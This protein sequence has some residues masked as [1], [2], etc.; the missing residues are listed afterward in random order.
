MLIILTK[1]CKD[2]DLWNYY[3][4]PIF[5]I[6]NIFMGHI[7]LCSCRI[8]ISQIFK[9]DVQLLLN[10]ESVQY[11][12]LNKCI[13]LYWTLNESNIGCFYFT[14]YFMNSSYVTDWKFYH[15]FFLKTITI[16]CLTYFFTQKLLTSSYS[17]SPFFFG[18]LI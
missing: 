12:V 6:W 16:S 18:F 10:W 17:H 2:G 14:Y 5:G 1:F 3:Y 15:L 13:F 8:L 7:L 11:A 4:K 9:Q